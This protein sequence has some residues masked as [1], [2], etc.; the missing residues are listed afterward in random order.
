MADEGSSRKIRNREFEEAPS[1]AT[2]ND[3]VSIG[4]RREA[5][6]ANRERGDE[7]QQSALNPSGEM[8]GIT[9]YAQSSSVLISSSSSMSYELMFV[10]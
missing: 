5:P 3:H 6:Q 2:L 8:E 7:T 10:V 9:G 4:L 1:G